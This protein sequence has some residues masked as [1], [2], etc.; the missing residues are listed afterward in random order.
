MEARTRS[1]LCNGS[2]GQR[3]RGFPCEETLTGTGDTLSVLLLARLP[4]I[5]L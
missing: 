4:Q 3:M 5:L 1:W 2:A